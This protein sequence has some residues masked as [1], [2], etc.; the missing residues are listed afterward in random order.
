MKNK[1]W[2]GLLCKCLSTVCVLY[3]IYVNIFPIFYL[4]CDFVVKSKLLS[5]GCYG[6][7]LIKI[8]FPSDNVQP[9]PARLAEE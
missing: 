1:P 9:H 6:L 7:L 4:L 5:N 3:R 2:I 8:Q